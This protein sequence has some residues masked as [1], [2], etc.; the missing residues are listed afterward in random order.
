MIPWMTKICVGLALVALAAWGESVR[1]DAGLLEG[2][3][4]SDPSIRVF[5]GVPFAAAPVGPLRWAPPQP[6]KPWKGVRAADKFG[7]HCV[8]ARVFDDIIFRGNM[9][10]DCLTL[11]VWTPAKSERERFP[12]YVWFYGGGFSAGGSDEP[13]YDGESIAQHGIVVV[14]VNYRLG[15]FGFF[16]HPELTAESPHKASGNYGLLD[17][18]AA[19]QWVRKNIVVF[20][21]DPRKVTIGGESAGSLSVSA[22]MAS[23]LSRGLFQQAIGESGAFLGSVGGRGMPSLAETEKP[24]SAFAAPVAAKSV[25]DLRAIPADKLLQEASKPA[26][27]FASWP[28]L[29]GYFLTQ[30]V[31]SVFAQASK[32]RFRS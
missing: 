16:A 1:V 12:V 27:G 26:G 31:A 11:T 21:G 19:L 25:A 29:D 30:D 6:V 9:S 18:V 17:Q 20:G 10:E 7:S 4:G 22:L 24:G 2:S 32:Q 28:S 14:N 23:P 13:R 5:R 8:Q 3:A 15:V